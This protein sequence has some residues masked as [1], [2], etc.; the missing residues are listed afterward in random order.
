MSVTIYHN[1]RCGK[2]RA[3]LALLQKKG[4]RPRVV[5][6]LKTPPDQA[7]LKRLLKL[8]GLTPR[9]LLRAKEAKAAGLDKP[10]LSDDAIIAGMVEHP[11]VIERPIVVA[12]SRAALG[13]PP[14]AVLKI[15]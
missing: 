14:E 10:G 7:E 13:R 1:P 6:Y 5:E 15:L 3:T 4:L 11:I 9:Q 8:L 12:G 2:S